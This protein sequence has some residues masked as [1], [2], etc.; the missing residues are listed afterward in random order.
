MLMYG[1]ANMC[2][3]LLRLMSCALAASYIE[4]EALGLTTRWYILL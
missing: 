3:I 1:Y 4:T 2:E